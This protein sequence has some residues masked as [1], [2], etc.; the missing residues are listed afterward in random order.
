MGHLFES[1]RKEQSSIAQLVERATVNRKVIGSTPVGRVFA[2][3]VGVMRVDALF[4]RH[5]PSHLIARIRKTS[6]DD[7]RDHA[8]FADAPPSRAYRSLNE[9]Y[10]SSP[11][12]TAEMQ[13][14]FTTARTKNST[15]EMNPITYV[16]S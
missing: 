10:G 1:V 5:I 13:N 6:R 9:S 4:V 11:F 12:V 16:A 8:A 2:P 14:T 3:R 7:E 15:Q